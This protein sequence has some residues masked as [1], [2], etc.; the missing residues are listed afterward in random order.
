MKRL[1]L[2]LALLLLP[3]QAFASSC[4]VTEFRLY[5]PSGV[6]V[7]DLESLVTDQTPVTTSGTSAQSAA[8][9]GD[10]KLIQVFCDTQSAM[11]YGASPTATTNNMPIA[12]GGT[13][14]FA[15]AGGKK[16]AFILRP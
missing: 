10:T 6:Q 12:A 16:V 15:V 2:A 1:L 7:A 8:L 4:N 11:A 5:A 13:I 3:A 9:S 14:Y